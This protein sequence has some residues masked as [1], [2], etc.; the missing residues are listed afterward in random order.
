MVAVE[1]VHQVGIVVSELERTVGWQERLLGARRDGAPTAIPAG[2]AR[3]AF[4]SLGGTRLLLVE[5]L[6]R[7]AGPP[8]ARADQVGACHVCIAV[9][10]VRE[11]H[12][13]LRR[14]GVRTSTPPA[15]ILA[16]VWSV[17][18]RDPDGVQ[19][20]LLQLGEGAAIHH[21]A[22]TVSSLER[23]LEWYERVLGLAPTYRSE[24]SG[25]LVSRMLGVAD[26]SYQVALLPVGEIQIELMEWRPSRPAGAPAGAWDV[27]GWH[28]AAEVADLGAVLERLG[29][30]GGSSRAAAL[31]VP[32]RPPEAQAVTDPDGVLV[33]LTQAGGPGPA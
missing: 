1:P 16:G 29:H 30:G 24:S 22:Y 28:L 6:V 11:A 32:A 19:Y 20:Q 3:C 14:H 7:G 31:A 27:G 15:E 9:P 21:L 4:T 26:A 17:Y 5:P 12:D 2:A 33:L 8:P 25:A 18:F 23:T 13:R 10:D